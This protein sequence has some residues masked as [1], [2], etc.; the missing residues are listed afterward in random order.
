MNYY[1]YNQKAYYIQHSE[2]GY[3]ILYA[4]IK[5][6]WN[7]TLGWNDVKYENTEIAYNNIIYNS[8]Q[9]AAVGLFMSNPEPQRAYSSPVEGT[10]EIIRAK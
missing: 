4:I 9:E 6:F 1:I 2:K 3:I 5:K 8:E 7:E 10:F